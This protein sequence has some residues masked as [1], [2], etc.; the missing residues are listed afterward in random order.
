MDIDIDS[1]L[2]FDEIVI[3]I[4]NRKFLNRKQ[5]DISQFQ[6]KDRYTTPFLCLIKFIMRLWSDSVLGSSAQREQASTDWTT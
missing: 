6:V 1:D 5:V 3:L 4:S 2:D